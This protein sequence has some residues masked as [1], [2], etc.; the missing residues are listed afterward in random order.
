MKQFILG[1]GF[2]LT[3]FQSIAGQIADINLYCLSIRFAQSRT[4][5]GGFEYTM[6]LTAYDTPAEFPNGELFP[7]FPLSPDAPTSHAAYYILEDELGFNSFFGAML[8]PVPEQIDQNNNLIPDFYEV[9]QG[10]GSVTTRGEFEDA[11]GGGSGTVTAVWSRPAGES[12][13]NCRLTLRSQVINITFNH[14]FEL[15]HYSGTF[16]YTRTGNSIAASVRAGWK[17][18]PITYFFAGDFQL[19]RPSRDIISL[20]P[21]T[22]KDGF[23]QVFTF[24]DTELIERVEKDYL[25]EFV[26]IDGDLSTSIE[27]FDYWI[28]RITDPN[29]ANRNG[30]PDLSDD[31]VTRDL[32]LAISRANNTLSVSITGDIGQTVR[33]EQTDALGAAANWTLTQSVTL[34]QDPKVIEFPLPE[35]AVRFW[36]VRSP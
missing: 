11:T 6:N 8:L 25:G 3:T 9:E 7:L 36:R 14:T 29:D 27:D 35:A 34:D 2:I 30:I 10:I 21:G 13:G 12:Y 32:R 28:L 22:M 4:T 16:D 19:T 18:D 23:D 15:S 17:G 5:V 1:L 20:K 31:L 33:L 24:L 26:L